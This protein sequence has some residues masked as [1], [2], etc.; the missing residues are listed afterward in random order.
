MASCGPILNEMETR[1][2]WQGPAPTLR[3]MTP[4]TLPPLTWL[5]AFDAAGR[6]GSFKAAAE[7]LHVTPSAISH[8][9]KSLEAHLGLPLFER[10]GARLALTVSGRAYW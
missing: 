1:G 7:A 8:Q 6:L 5:R 4:S 9:I 10:A 3:R 2:D